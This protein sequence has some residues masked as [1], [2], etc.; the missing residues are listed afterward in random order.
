MENYLIPLVS[1]TRGTSRGAASSCYVLII[2]ETL[3]IN[4]GK[5][6]DIQGILVEDHMDVF[7]RNDQE[8]VNA[9]ISELNVFQ[10]NLGV[11]VSMGSLR[12][13]NARLYM[14]KNVRW[15]NEKIKVVFLLLFC[16]CFL[17]S[18]CQTHSHVLCWGHWY[19]CFGFLVTSPLGFK[20]RMGPVLFP[21]RRRI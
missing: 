7:S 13:S 18:F 11:Q 3:A 4:L 12:N 15:S 17:S 21:L 10:P 20:V 9:I 14:Q 19:P 6:V 1:G 2:A 8:S 5:K 16:F